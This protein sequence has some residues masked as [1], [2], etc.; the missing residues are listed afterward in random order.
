[1]ADFEYEF[2][3]TVLENKPLPIVTL[4][5]KKLLEH[6]GNP[7]AELCT[8]LLLTANY[9]KGLSLAGYKN[10]DKEEKLQETK[11]KLINCRIEGFDPDQLLE[12]V[13]NRRNQLL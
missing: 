3:I 2:F 8:T 12:A 7:F 5:D 4:D 13:E 1:M 6:Y 11:Q 10:P 9:L